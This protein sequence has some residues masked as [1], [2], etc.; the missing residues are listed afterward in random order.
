MT[1][2]LVAVAEGP[3]VFDTDTVAAVLAERC[4][5]AS[6]APPRPED[7]DPSLGQFT[8]ESAGDPAT[9]LIADLLPT[10]GKASALRRP[11]TC[12]PTSSPN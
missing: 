9:F 7:L 4:P 1:E 6:W 2:V 5:P 11:G 12:S 8:V 10:E 3:Y